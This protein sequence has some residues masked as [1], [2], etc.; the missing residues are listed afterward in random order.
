MGVLIVRDAESH[1]NPTLAAGATFGTTASSLA[2]GVR[3]AQDVAHIAE[4]E[5]LVQ[6]RCAEGTGDAD[7]IDASIAVSS[8]RLTVGDANHEDVVRL[9]PGRW[10]VHIEADPPDMPE[11]V[12]IWLTPGRA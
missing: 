1:D 8:G 11:R 7:G 6:V 12:V 10:R 4:S 9:D 5:F 3:H 2:I